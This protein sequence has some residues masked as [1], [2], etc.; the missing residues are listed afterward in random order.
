MTVKERIAR[1]QENMAAAG[2]DYYLVPTADYHESEYVGAHFAVRR[3]L[4][5]F[6]GSAG[7]M[8]IGREEACLWTD[9]R[10]FIQAEKQLA[11]SGITLMKMGTEGT[12]TVEAYIVEKVPENGVL[13]FDGKV[14][15]TAMAERLQKK[16]ADKHVTFHFEEDLVES[17]FTERAPLSA[18]PA[19]VLKPEY[20]GKSVAEKL[21]DVH[22][23][24]EEQ[25]AD[26]CIITSLDDIAWLYNMR[27][28]DVPD[29]P[30]VLSYTI[31]YL[32]HAVLFVNEA[33]LNDE[34]RT[35]FQ[36]NAVEI[37]PYMDIY[38]YV[39]TMPAKHILLNKNKVNFAITGSLPEEAEIIHG[40][41]PT[42]LMKAI[43]NETEIANTKNAHIK[44][45]VAMVKFIY[46]L[47]KNI[48]KT[49]ITEISAADYLEARRREQE[50]FVELSFGT[51]AAYNEN[52]AMMHYSATPENFA[53][54]APS[55]MFL[56]DSGGH[57]LEGTTD[58]TRTFILGEIPEEWKRD[59][60]LTLKGHLAL[61]N[62]KFLY[63]CTGL[64]LDILCRGPLWNIGIDYRCGTGHGVGHILNVH[65]GPNGF[66]YRMVPERLDSG[67]LEAG[68]IT[69]D[70]PGVYTEGSHGVR[71]ENELLCVKAEKNEYGQFMAFEP[72]TCCPIDKKG[73]LP[74][75]L[76]PE[77]IEQLNRYHKMVYEK[78]SPYFEGEELAWLQDATAPL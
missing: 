53:V 76:G 60:T 38:D 47:E 34:L 48:G 13:G 8:V 72:I 14:I 46:W 70:E 57:Y 56:V 41:D 30:I 50:G 1:L 73:I 28:N 23:K 29:F 11:G 55:G 4:S 32:D 25:G 69:T 16:L 51:I 44:D 54:L 9:G 3:F 18:E 64:N 12:P 66:R 45:G 42:Y 35:V 78:L 61:Q 21:A 49:E 6:T 74:E 67:V 19:W 5:G 31:L 39:K 77:G 37:R 40:S 59:Y 43:K 58:I 17:F 27:G 52:A 20:A 75:L 22:R 36:E 24:M 10:Y 33:V 65:E 68:M 62:A 15:N 26:A 63:G 2:V 7:T 71:I